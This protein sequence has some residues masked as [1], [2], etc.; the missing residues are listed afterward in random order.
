MRGIAWST[1]SVGDMAHPFQQMP[2]LR[3]F[4]DAAVEEGCEERVSESEIIGPRGPTRARYLRGTNGV[5]YI[6]P[7]MAD[8]DRLTPTTMASMARALRLKCYLHVYKHLLQ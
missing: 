4:I 5:V 6:L 2:T 1:L 3:E 7:E 8:G